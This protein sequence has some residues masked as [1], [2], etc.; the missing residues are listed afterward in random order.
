MALMRFRSLL[1]GILIGA[2]AWPH[3]PGLAVLVILLLP[4]VRR[5]YALAIGYYAGASYGLIRG[6]ATFFPHA[7]L[8]LGGTFWLASA[9]VLAL[10]YLIY[11]AFVASE[12]CY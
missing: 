7:G 6:T 12:C 4:V 10:P 2:V 8:A 1:A 5:R 11:D 3:A 9:A